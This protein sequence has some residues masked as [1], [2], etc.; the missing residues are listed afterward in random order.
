MAVVRSKKKTTATEG[1]RNVTLGKT[2]SLQ[3]K[4][5]AAV[6]QPLP[7]DIVNEQEDDV[8]NMEQPATN[9]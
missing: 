1:S 5:V 3:G 9:S 7:V 8:S 2:L 6:S 4:P